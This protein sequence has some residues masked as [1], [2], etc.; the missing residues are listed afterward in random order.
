M[1]GRRKITWPAPRRAK[2][3][4]GMCLVM[5]LAAPFPLPLPSHSTPPSPPAPAKDLIGSKC[6]VQSERKDGSGERRG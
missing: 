3:K 5:L 1:K 2:G 4:E 6:A